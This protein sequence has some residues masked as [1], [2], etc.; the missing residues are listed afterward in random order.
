MT[1]LT[2]DARFLTNVRALRLGN[3]QLPD[4]TTEAQ[5]LIDVRSL[6]SDISRWNKGAPAFNGNGKRTFALSDSACSWCLDG[7]VHREGRRYSLG[8]QMRA[9]DILGAAVQPAEPSPGQRLQPHVWYNDRPQTTHA[10]ILALLD[11]AID[12]VKSAGN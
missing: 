11:K 1:N 9:T 7:A 3:G 5:L 2:P 4:L 8:A 6:L 10:D 12:S